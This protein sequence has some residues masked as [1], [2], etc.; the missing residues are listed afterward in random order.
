M[1]EGLANWL[2]NNLFLLIV[3]LIFKDIFLLMQVV[4]WWLFFGS[5][6][7]CDPS[8]IIETFEV[9]HLSKQT[10]HYSFV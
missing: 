5:L 6:T 10:R 1:A 4:K 8:D 2:L 3:F 9:L 7:T